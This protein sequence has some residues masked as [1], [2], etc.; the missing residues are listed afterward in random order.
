MEDDHY[1]LRSRSDSEL[2]DWVIEHKPGTDEYVAGIHESMRRVAIIEELI[3]K[4]EAPCR[5]RECVAVVLAV[6]S[7]IAAIVVVVFFY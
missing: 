3:E 4:R 1:S 6:V 7:I 2:H 5:R